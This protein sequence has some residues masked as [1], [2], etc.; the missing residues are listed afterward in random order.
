MSQGTAV[1]T[2]VLVIVLVSATGCPNLPAGGGKTGDTGA[3][4]IGGTS[5]GSTQGGGTPVQQPPAAPEPVVASPVTVTSPKGG[6]IYVWG[7]TVP[8]AWDTGFS[9]SGQYAG[10][11]I[12]ARSEPESQIVYAVN[13]VQ[14]DGNYTMKTTEFTC[15]Q[16]GTQQYL[17]QVDTN[18]DAYSGTSASFS[19]RDSSPED[20]PG[21]RVVVPSRIPRI[22]PPAM[23]AMNQPVGQIQQFTDMIGKIVITSPDGN[24]GPVPIG[25]VIPIRWDMGFSPA[26]EVVYVDLNEE[27]GKFGGNI[28]GHIPNT[29]QYDWDTGLFSL[30]PGRY[31]LA[32]CTVDN[33]CGKS[34]VFELIEQGDLFRPILPNMSAASNQFGVV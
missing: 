6:D 22:S 34:G 7:G 26:S 15:E 32:M 28:A 5:G 21:V 11:R 8:V 4:L 33:V 13:M 17:V 24:L 16:K 2:L 29:G 14:N 1:L 30:Q 18:D 23:R 20:I 10:V 25:S 19:I 12:V 9:P 3:P 31:Y 27:S